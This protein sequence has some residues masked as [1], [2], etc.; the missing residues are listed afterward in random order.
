MLP[1][2]LAPTLEDVA[3]QSGV[4]TATV[5]RV[6]NDPARVR[7]E[8][9]E[10]VE[11][12]VTSL[13][14]TPHFGARMLASNRTNTVGAV[15]P[16]MDNAIFAQGLQA[17]QEELAEAGVTLLIATSNYD[18]EREARQIRTLLG[19][20]VDGLVLIGESRSAEAYDLMESR[21]VPFVLVWTWRADCPW[22]CVGFDNRAA[23]RQTAER[24]LELGHRR[25]AMIAGIP[26]GNDRAASRVEGVREALAPHGLPLPLIEAEYALDAGQS[27]AADLLSRTPRP[28]V[29]ICGNDVLAAGA[30][31]AV[32]EMGLR[33]PQEVS[34]VGFDD[35]D[36]ARLLDPPLATVHVPHRRMG[37]AAARLLLQLRDKAPE[38]K[39]T[40]FEAELI[41][42]GSL[43]PVSLA[44]A[45]PR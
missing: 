13:G 38:A 33:V 21:G 4:S 10:K 22:P 31:L 28:T 18:A 35:I 9:R 14:Y 32:R 7:R 40:A 2:K 23:A 20:G 44:G 34:L 16:T 12:A 6:L 11:A 37:Q 36:I 26:D 42:R 19:R 41:E 5:S 17:L 8:T 39:N 1:M 24:V 15:I 27:A 45:E 25:I 29:I 30:M 43:A 3:R